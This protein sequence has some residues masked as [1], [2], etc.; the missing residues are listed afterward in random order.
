[1]KHPRG[2]S[3]ETAANGDLLERDRLELIRFA[4]ADAQRQAIRGLLDRGMLN[5]TSHHE[6]EWL[7]R[8]PVARKLREIGVPFEWLTEHA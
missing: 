2:S 6:E 5:F 1:M 7:V 4:S 3:S 8:T